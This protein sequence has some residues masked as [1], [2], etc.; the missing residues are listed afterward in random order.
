MTFMMLGGMI[1]GAWIMDIG[2]ALK[3]APPEA[4]IATPEPQIAAPAAENPEQSG[5]M[6]HD[7]SVDPETGETTE[8]SVIGFVD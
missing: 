5:F 2:A 8:I 3:A 4:T 6:T 1:L 7:V